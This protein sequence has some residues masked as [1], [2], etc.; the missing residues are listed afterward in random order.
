MADTLA[1]APDLAVDELK[2]RARRRLV[3][4]IVLALA[5]A[6]ILPLAARERAQAA[7]R[8]RVGP[9]S[10]DR[11]GKFVNP[12]SPGKGSESKRG[13]DR[14][15]HEAP[16]LRPMAQPPA[17]S[18]RA[19]DGSA[20]MRSRARRRAAPMCERA[21]TRRRTAPASRTGDARTRSRANRGAAEPAASKPHSNAPQAGTSSGAG[22]GGA[23]AVQ[24][25]AFTDDKGARAGEQAEE[26][27]LS[28]P[29]S[30]RRRE[31]QG[32]L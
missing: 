28:P 22:A 16:A 30:S 2:R 29:T 31:R 9:D 11:Q 18:A 4:A 20:A 19:G 21:T 1:T 12:L 3:G 6:V 13:S 15:R 25:A 17:L 8:R 23:F 27:R 24:V 32:A 14:C 26:G 7:R 10:A 5:A